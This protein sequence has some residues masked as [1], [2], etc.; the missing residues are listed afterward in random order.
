MKV[1]S[2]GVVP[3][4][5]PSVPPRSF[6]LRPASE[7]DGPFLYY[8]AANAEYPWVRIVEKGFPLFP[9]IQ[10]ALW[11]Q[12]HSLFIVLGDDRR[13]LGAASIFH[14]RL[15]HGTAWCDIVPLARSRTPGL[16][17][18]VA[19]QIVAMAFAS[20]PIRKL[21]GMFHSYQEPI[22]AGLKE[23]SHEE[24]VLKEHFLHDGI[25]WDRVICAIWRK[26]WERSHPGTDVYPGEFSR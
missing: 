25:Y 26:T 14:V 6:S 21:Y 2:E 23:A 10:T 24:A 22:F 17:D 11:R 4:G 5:N 20:L 18:P 15:H 19:T 16:W 7:E 3:S 9:D 12:V 13:P 8:L 1:E